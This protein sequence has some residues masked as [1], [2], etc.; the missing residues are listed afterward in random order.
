MGSLFQLLP[1]SWQRHPQLRGFEERLT[2][3]HQ[4]DKKEAQCH[5]MTQLTCFCPSGGLT[6]V[7]G[8]PNFQHGV[9]L[10]TF[11]KGEEEKEFWQ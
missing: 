3:E 6:D 8:C 9:F 5:C 7:K 11:F 10:I 2:S 4:K 1:F